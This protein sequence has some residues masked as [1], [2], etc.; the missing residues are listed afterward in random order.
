[1]VIDRASAES[2][3][4]TIGDDTTVLTPER[5]P[6]T[7]VGL[8]T[9]GDTDQLGGATYVA[10]DTATDQAVTIRERDAMTQERIALGQ[11]RG[12]LADRLLGS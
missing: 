7:I 4:L 11:V 12:Y 8:A 2:G 5:V 3:G 10:F 6:A 1:M 9:Y